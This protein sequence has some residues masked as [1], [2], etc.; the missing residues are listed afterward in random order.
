MCVCVCGFVSWSCVLLRK[1]GNNFCWFG[2]SEGSYVCLVR[3]C[4]IF[5][6]FM[7]WMGYA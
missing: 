3:G 2:Y 7:F 4:K 5:T 6:V 1:E